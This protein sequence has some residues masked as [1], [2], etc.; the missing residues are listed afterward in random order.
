MT[1]RKSARVATHL[2]RSAILAT[3]VF[4]GAALV[5]LG[6][7]PLEILRVAPRAAVIG[8]DSDQPVTRVRSLPTAEL[9]GQPTAEVPG[10]QDDR[11]QRVP[12]DPATQ[13]GEADG[14]VPDGVT[15]FD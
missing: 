4:V 10:P 13:L 6:P 15:V 12:K 3:S 5:G 9:S 2:T 7:S 8:I 1:Y 14:V 11:D